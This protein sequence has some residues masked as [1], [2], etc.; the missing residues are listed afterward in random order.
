VVARPADHLVVDGAE[1]AG[2]VDLGDPGFGIEGVGMGTAWDG[3]GSVGSTVR[4]SG[5]P[6]W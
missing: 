5:S 1:A 3:T 4:P 2:G 6:G